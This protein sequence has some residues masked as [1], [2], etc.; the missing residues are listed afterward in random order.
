MYTWYILFYIKTHLYDS[1][2][3]VIKR[4]L[5]QSL[6]KA[7][8]KS[9]CKDSWHLIIYLFSKFWLS[10][11]MYD[12]Y[13]RAKDRMAWQ[14][15]DNYHTHVCMHAPHFPVAN[16]FGTRNPENY[17]NFLFWICTG[18]RIQVP[19]LFWSFLSSFLFFFLSVSILEHHVGR[20]WNLCLWKAKCE[21]NSDAH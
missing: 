3:L 19:P 15:G 4:I 8:K 2:V 13:W 10:W 5:L 1:D 7:K 12:Y 20:A 18:D 17:F 14:K 6:Y 9:F 21:T 11:H 16:R